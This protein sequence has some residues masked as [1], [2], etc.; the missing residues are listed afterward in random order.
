[1]LFLT[2]FINNKKKK[3]KETLFLLR[4]PFFKTNKWSLN[5]DCEGDIFCSAVKMQNILSSPTIFL[6]KKS[7]RKGSPNGKKNLFAQFCYFNF[8]SPEI[9]PSKCQTSLN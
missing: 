3:K 8:G 1:M 7:C 2:F 9:E 6:D 4:G 5:D